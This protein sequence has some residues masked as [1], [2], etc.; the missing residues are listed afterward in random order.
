MSCELSVGGGKMEPLAKKS[1]SVLTN[2]GDLPLFL[3]L[4][5]ESLPE[6]DIIEQCDSS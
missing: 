2:V 4:D 6:K 1:D 3:E 5:L